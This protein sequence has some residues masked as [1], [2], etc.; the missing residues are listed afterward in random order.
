[1]NRIKSTVKN[2]SEAT[3]LWWSTRDKESSKNSALKGWLTRRKKE[4]IE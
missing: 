2:Q 4:I 3:K 1:M